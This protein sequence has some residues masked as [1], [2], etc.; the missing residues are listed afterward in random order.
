MKPKLT[1]QAAEYS[2]K[3]LIDEIIALSILVDDLKALKRKLS[4]DVY[5]IGVSC[6]YSYLSKAS[7]ISALRNLISEIDL[8]IKSRVK[9]SKLLMTRIIKSSKKYFEESPSDLVPLSSSDLFRGGIM[10]KEISGDTLIPH[11]LLLDTGEIITYDEAKARQVL[12]ECE[13]DELEFYLHTNP[14]DKPDYNKYIWNKLK[15]LS[16]LNDY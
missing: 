4:T 5:H 11:I 9:R 2:R 8:K 6:G 12:G 1:N 3:R 7:A 10:L 16:V 14:D 15:A 13:S